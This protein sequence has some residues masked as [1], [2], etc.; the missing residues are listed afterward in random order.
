MVIKRFEDI[1]V[2]QESRDLTKKIYDLTKN[3]AFSKDFGLTGQL[4]RAAVSIMNNITEGFDSGSNAEFIRFLGYSRR[5]SSEV[6]C[7][8]YVALDQKYIS[9]NEFGLVY[10]QTEK[11][12][13]M[14]TAFMK[15]LRTS[16]KKRANE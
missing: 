15:Y 14:I 2:W 8:L 5:S 6:Q 1:K 3:S 7:C 11:V 12:R 10:D 16:T 13:R 4:Q 9:N